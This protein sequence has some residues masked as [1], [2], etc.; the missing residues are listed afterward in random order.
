MVEWIDS[1]F[2]LEREF[3]SLAKHPLCP[4]VGEVKMLYEDGGGG[5]VGGVGCGKLYLVRV[6][7]YMEIRERADILHLG[8]PG[9]YE[10][11]P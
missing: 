10:T 9:V 7:Y 6:D 2:P 8:S 5:G 4:V 3:G 11:I 1:R